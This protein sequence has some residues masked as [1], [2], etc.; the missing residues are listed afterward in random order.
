M[1]SSLIAII[2]QVI[3]KNILIIFNINIIMEELF[4][5]VDAAHIR[6]IGE[7]SI[8]NKIQAILE[9]VKNSYDADSLDCI[10][11]FVGKKINDDV[12]KIEQ[13]IIEDHGIGMTKN[14]LKN[15]LMKVGT[16]EKI[17]EKFSPKLHR[18]VSGEKGMGHYSVQRLGKMVNIITTP[19]PFKS[20]D[21]DKLDHTTYHLELNWKNYTSGKDFEKISN[22]LYVVEKQNF[23]TRIEISE[24]NDEW[25]MEGKNSDLVILIKNLNTIILPKELQDNDKEK[26]TSHVMTKGFNVPIP[27]M[28]GDL[29]DYAPHKIHAKLIDKKIIYDIYHTKNSKITTIPR[30]S[31]SSEHAICGNAELTLYW[32]P[33]MLKDW[34]PRIFT[35]ASLGEQLKNKFG[36]K[37][38]N[39]KIRIM[40]YG[41]QDDWL[42]LGQRKSGPNSG[43]FMRNNHILGF[44]KLTRKNNPNII[45]TTTRQALRENDA[46]KSL[47]ANFIM[48]V[49]E[50]LEKN[51]KS[52]KDE[53]IKSKEHHKNI[54][55]NEIKHIL[56]H[57]Q[58]SKRLDAKSKTNMVY[59]LNLISNHVKLNDQ[60]YKKD[61]E[62]ITSNLEMYRNL[63]SIGIQTLAFNHEIIDPISWIKATLGPIIKDD[64]IKSHRDFDS[65]K[66]CYIKINN[67]SI[68]SEYIKEF[69]SFLSGDSK[70]IKEPSVINIDKII[71]HI[72]VGMLSLLNNND[73]NIVIHD[74]ILIGKIPNLIMNRASFES[75]IIN[76]I[77]NSVRSLKRVNRK[78]NIR[79]KISKT[80]N[81]L[82]IEFADNGIG[83]NGGNEDRIFDPFFTTYGNI[84]DLGTGMGL[85]IIK[86]IIE[87]DY[88]GRIILEKNISEKINPGKGM[89]LFSIYF[90]LSEVTKNE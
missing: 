64:E 71:K 13:I 55:I 74:P 77:S 23:G 10:I 5:S 27:E 54:T 34:A 1:I 52:M 41:E 88:K 83:V 67:M 35:R 32:F 37:I 30:R 76:L 18:R 31:I 45:E 7:Q 8:S 84:D 44:L 28:K 11:T 57:I 69:S 2:I 81:D 3:Y 79:I 36:I 61:I 51:V 39:D 90:P 49:I 89:A 4:H 62:K 29:L 20:R 63:S 70:I 33:G 72:C 15:K 17:D 86:E 26:F 9:L 80:S 60:E 47:K 21:F 19:E 58:D 53:E 14:D 48:D 82:K 85:T 66:T 59:S 50:L 65:L 87:N 22:K 12:I 40:P 24:L 6:N 16:N 25:T 43:S 68:W 42:N 56:D 75:I 46:F 73:N 38:Y 78:R